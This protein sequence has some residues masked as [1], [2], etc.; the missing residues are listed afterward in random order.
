VQAA[1]ASFSLKILPEV[2]SALSAGK[3][4]V[5]LE[6]TIIS[7]GTPRVPA[8]CDTDSILHAWPQSENQL[9]YPHAPAICLHPSAH[10]FS[11][12]FSSERSKDHNL[13]TQ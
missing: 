7:H 4:V 1:S 11:T 8:A 9:P 3:A 10:K 13:L 5:A 2:Q 6:S 12:T